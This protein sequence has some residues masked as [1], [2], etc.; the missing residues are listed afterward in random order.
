MLKAI[1]TAA[2]LMASQSPSLDKVVAKAN[3]VKNN[4][5]ETC[6]VERGQV[7]PENSYRTRIQ[8]CKT[9]RDGENLYMATQEKDFL[10]IQEHRQTDTGYCTI[11][12]RISL[13]TG[14]YETSINSVR[15][16][17]FDC[18]LPSEQN[19]IG[20]LDLLSK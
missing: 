2:M 13:L 3:E 19:L 6:W 10:V 8:M 4:M 11:T 15:R 12:H 7:L 5:T 16:K 18:Y 14:E 17:S 9:A 20:V 1:I